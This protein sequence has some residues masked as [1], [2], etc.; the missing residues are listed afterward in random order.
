MKNRDTFRFKIVEE[1]TGILSEDLKTVI[2]N[3]TYYLYM[4]VSWFL[5]GWLQI[6]PKEN[7]DDLIDNW[8]DGSFVSI[9][10]AKNRAH[11][12][13]ENI[14]EDMRIEEAKKRLKKELKTT[15]KVIVDF[16]IDINAK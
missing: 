13:V 3:S 1:T 2:K 16:E 14:L 7:E 5:G 6:M 10:A 4:K 8:I 15:T 9:E 11:E 12:Y